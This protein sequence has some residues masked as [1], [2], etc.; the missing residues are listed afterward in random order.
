VSY[1]GKHNEANGENNRDGAGDNMSWNCG[2]EG[3]TDDAAINALRDRQ[4]RNLIATLLLSQGVPM[5][6]AGDEICNTKDGNNNTYCQDNE[7]TWLNWDL[8]EAQ[9]SLLSFTQSVIALRKMNP[10]FQRQKFFQGR[11]IRGDFER[12]ISWFSPD[13]RPMND[14][15]WNAGFVRCL[16]VYLDGEMIGEMD[17][18]GERIRGESVLVLLNAHHELISFKLPAPEKVSRWKPLL[19]TRQLPKPQFMEAGEEYPLGGRSLAVLRIVTPDKDEER[20]DEATHVAK[21]VVALRSQAQAEQ[22]PTES[23]GGT[24]ANKP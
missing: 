20:R 15:S 6:L 17:P 2:H 13:G 3:P 7:L 21:E 19:D 23:A 10:V 12:D 22:P 9:Q 8:D 11:S 16:G 1:N 24:T 4:K 5:L 18:K 14:E